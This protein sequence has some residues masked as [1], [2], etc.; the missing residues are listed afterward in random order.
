LPAEETTPKE[1]KPPYVESGSATCVFGRAGGSIRTPP[2]LQM[3]A[4]IIKVHGVV[5]EPSSPVSADT[6][7]AEKF[8]YNGRLINEDI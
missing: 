3:L 1:R 7:K 6:S 8:G 2:D 5:C 4:P